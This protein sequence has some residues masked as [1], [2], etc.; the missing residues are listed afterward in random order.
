MVL[1]NNDFRVYPAGSGTPESRYTQLKDYHR[2][3]NFPLLCANV[4]VKETGKLIQ[5]VKDFKNFSF[6]GV[7]IAVVGIT[8][9]KPE[10]RN[11]PDVADLDFLDPVETL[12]GVLSSMKQK[13]DINLV[14]SHAGN[15]TPDFLD[16]ELA[17][18]DGVAAVIGADSHKII[19]PPEFEMRDGQVVPIT[20]AGG[21][22]FTFLG[23]LDMTFQVIDGQMQLI[24]YS[25]RLYNV[26]YMD[27]EP[28]PEITKIID[29]YEALLEEME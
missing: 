2:D 24:E 15:W 26:T 19:D 28:D 27:V 8:S 20:Q 29:Y 11:W 7:K 14:L 5:N 13:S 4:I 12:E 3:Q 22:P 21:E 9:M 17:K 6:D 23:R 1:G 25:G 16:H 10:V 18:V